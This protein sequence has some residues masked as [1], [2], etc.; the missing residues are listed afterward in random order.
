MGTCTF[1]MFEVSFAMA[2]DSAAPPEHVFTRGV[3]CYGVCVRRFIIGLERQEDIM[4][5]DHAGF[6]IMSDL[7][8]IMRDTR[9]EGID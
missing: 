4:F 9:G 2:A 5:E 3:L 6:W 1:F 7:V 8:Y